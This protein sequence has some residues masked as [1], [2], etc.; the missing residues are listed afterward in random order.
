MHRFSLLGPWHLFLALSNFLT[1]FGS[2]DLF[3]FCFGFFYVRFLGGLDRLL[4]YQQQKVSELNSGCLFLME[5]KLGDKYTEL[6]L[7]F[8]KIINTFKSTFTGFIAV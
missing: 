2:V 7:F 4:F 3:G 6:R 1:I 8:P 5:M